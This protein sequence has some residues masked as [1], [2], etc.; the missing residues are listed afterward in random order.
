MRSAFFLLPVWFFAFAALGVGV[1]RAGDT[2][3]TLYV[4]LGVLGVCVA[5]VL[6]V[7]HRRIAELER[8]LELLRNKQT[9]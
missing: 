1:W 2:F 3:G 8:G 5:N 4:G 9:P 7:H 6:M